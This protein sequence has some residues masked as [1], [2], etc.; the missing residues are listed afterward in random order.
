MYNMSANMSVVAMQMQTMQITKGVTQ[1]MGTA[2]KTMGDQ[3]ANMDI[4]AINTMM[5]DFAKE[6][7]KMG[8]KMDLVNDGMD[9]G[10][11]EGEADDIYAQICDEIG[12]D[13]GIQGASV[14]TSKINVQGQQ[15]QVADQGNAE[16]LDDLEAR[17]ANLGA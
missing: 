12:I 1:I 5:R 7:D 6:S 2:A 9:V 10:M 14:G 4:S 13:S 16:E 3:N 17:L 11:D 8:M 15:Q